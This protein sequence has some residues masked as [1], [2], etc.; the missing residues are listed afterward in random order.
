[1]PNQQSV[2]F[3]VIPRGVTLDSA[4]PVSIFVTP[5]LSGDPTLSSF[6]DWRHWTTLLRDNGLTI[7]LVCAAATQTV[8]V[9]TSVLRP[10]LWEA[11]FADDTLVNPYTFDDYSNRGI[12]TYPVRRALSALKAIYQTAGVAL[13]LPRGGPGEREENVLRRELVDMI[14]GLQINWSPALGEE[15]RNEVRISGSPALFARGLGTDPALLDSEGLI[16]EHPDPTRNRAAAQPFAVFHHMPT[17]PQTTPFV[18]DWNKALD[19]HQALSAINAYPLLQR[20]LGLVFDFDLPAEFIAPT[21]GATP[22]TI[23][24]GSVQPGWPWAV[25]TTVPS[26]ATAYIS[27]AAGARTLFLT[28]PRV[29]VDTS[30]PTLVIG[31]LNLDPGRFGL[32][33]VDVDGGMHKAIMLAETFV[34]D[35]DANGSAGGPAAALHPEVFDPEATLPSLRSGGFTLYADGRAVGLLDTIGQN[36]AFN[37]AL[38]ANGN[39]PRPFFAED[40]VRGWRL[41]VWD[42][43]TGAWQSLHRRRGTYRIGEERFGPAEDEGF[44]QLAA[45]Q[46]APGAQPADNDIYLHEAIARWPG[47]SLSAPRPGKHLSR[48]ADPDKAIP[49]DAPDPD[50]A[51]NEPVT[52][53]KMK[54]EFAV[55]RGSLPQ[56]RFGR[57]YRLRARAVDLA[58]NSLAL[59]DPLADLLAQ[60]FALPQDPEGFAYLRYEPVAAP[61]VVMRDAAAVTG[62]GSAVDRPVI[63]TFNGTPSLDGAAADTSASDRHILPPRASVEICEHLGIF[64]DAAGHLRG[65]AAT[66]T[67]IGARDGG[68][69]PLSSL[70][71]AGKTDNYPLI[72]GAAFTPLPYLPDPSSRGAAFRDFPGTGQGVRATVAPGAGGDAAINYTALSDPN[73][74]PGSATLVSFQGGADWQALVGFRLALAEP[75]AGIRHAPPHWDPTNRVLTVFLPKGSVFTLPLTSFIEPDDLALMGQ[76]QWLRQYIERNT[77]TNPAQEVLEPGGVMDQIAHVLQRAVEGGHWMLT[78]PRLLTFVHAVQ[79]PLGHPR[80]IPLDVTHIEPRPDADPLQTAPIAGRQDPTELA[81]ITA[82]RR[83]GAPEA[84]LIGAL[85]IHGASTAKIDITAAWDEPVDDLAQPGPTTAQRHEHI[86]EIKLNSLTEWYIPADAQQQRS[87]GYYDPEHDQIAFVRAGDTLGIPG[88]IPDQLPLADAAPRHF[89][90]DPKHRRIRYTATA[91]SRFREYFDPA[92]EFTRDS[93]PVTVDIPASARPLAP[94]VRYVIPTFGWERETHTNL[95]RSVRFGGG[96]RVYL[97]RPWFS[98][99]EDELLGVA[100]WSSQNGTL[101]RDKFK[102]FITQWGMDPIWATAGLFSVPAYS[103]FA[104]GSPHEFAL[105]LAEPAAAAGPGGPPGFIDVVGFAPEFDPSRGLWYSDLTANT[106]TA[107]YTPFIRLALVRYQPHALPDAK[108]SRVVLADF[109]QLTPDRAA[110]VTSD[111][112]HPRTLRVVVSGVAP[113][114]PPPVSEARPAP[115]GP[116][117]PP[118]E[119]TLRVQQRDP[120]FVSDLAWTDA[121]AGVATIA[122]QQS[123]P[124]AGQPDLELFTATVTFAQPPQAGQFRLVIEETEYIAA[125]YAVTEGDRRTWPGRLIYAEIFQI[126]AGLAGAP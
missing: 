40:L 23:A 60:S 10:A 15:L 80:F 22:G 99:G 118:T 81:P 3:T 18:P 74:R 48:Y 111:P 107:T 91:T 31:L 54:A 84:Y 67:L 97:E 72:A 61:L 116:P 28:A 20:A 63:R 104:G 58:G 119:I 49:P 57:R 108:V 29:L 73:P 25:P 53:F 105:T 83:L 125:D 66:W 85:K 120:G 123:G 56:L 45:T 21:G 9:D 100:L 41:D 14:A 79:Q 8:Q 96:L 114:G 33:Q 106:F 17:P 68:E 86:E 124:A 89:F 36:K 13:A 75:A 35:P 92:L 117:P 115:P 70:T 24:V 71:V 77:V 95:K 76:W 19:F 112:F 78:P 46:P 38:E 126:D 103:N 50:Y 101:D 65:D 110:M 98:S 5:R 6:P 109:A 69:L 12:I 44:V 11:L 39:Q 26:L 2:L 52:P 37:D 16:T 94:V 121:P 4:R 82:W 1:M 51:E 42:S 93:A 43:R 122:V 27:L 59:N 102:P 113:Q 32:A 30:A 90:G 87:V 88:P 34:P 62:P 7:D 64:D 47:W 55:V